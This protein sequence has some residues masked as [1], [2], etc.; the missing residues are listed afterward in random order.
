MLR[1]LVGSEM[2][3]R[4]RVST[5]STGKPLRC[6][7]EYILYTSIA[8]SIVAYL[9]YA[10]A[11]IC[12]IHHDDL[13]SGTP[14][15]QAPLWLFAPGIGGR[16]LFG[17]LPASVGYDLND[18]QWRNFVGNIP[19]LGPVLLAY[20]LGARY[21][22]SSHEPNTAVTMKPATIPSVHIN[23]QPQEIAVESNEALASRQSMLSKAFDA[24]V[25]PSTAPKSN[26]ILMYYYAIGGALFVTC[27]LYT[28][29]AADEEDSVDLG[30]RR[31][32]KKKNNT[33]QLCE[34]SLGYS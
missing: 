16:G 18:H 31:I 8:V 4:D 25:N 1:S 13:K 10:T 23:G 3:I 7:P 24:C 9:V 6:S 17:L 27:L 2:C 5:Q 29:D 34:G 19:L 26:N 30:G 20:M 28:S 14:N 21:I 12:Y 22:R 32:I 11:R 33:V 15:L